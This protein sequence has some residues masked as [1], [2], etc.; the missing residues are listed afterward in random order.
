MGRVS[1]LV[2]GG[3][4]AVVAIVLVPLAVAFACAP[5][6]SFTLDAPSAEVGA[7]VSGVVR[8]V[9][10]TRG[11]APS[12][13]PVY[14]R[15]GSASGPVVWEGRPNASGEAAVRFTVP[16]VQPGVHVVI[17]TQ[18][19]A[20]G[21]PA[22]GTPART[23]LEVLPRPVPSATTT[24]AAPAPSTTAPAL[25][26]PDPAPT[27]VPGPT[28]G[29][30]T[31][32]AR[33]TARAAAPPATTATVAPA[34]P[35]TSVPPSA[36]PAPAPPATGPPA[37]AAPAT[38]SAPGGDAGSSLAAQPAASTSEGGAPLALVAAGVLAGLAATG[39]VVR[40]RR[41]SPDS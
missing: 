39:L 21:A 3:M 4:A 37:T 11:G 41:P 40:R 26:E 29:A 18:N 23:T 13:E 28:A 24:T 34:P 32:T 6:A 8:G 30:P 35:T 10:A 38:T 25:A 16:D 1:V 22:P 9:F 36:A 31:T 19:N 20:D 17:A 15:F 5:L 7:E 2:V 33:A 27:T 12:A 14:V